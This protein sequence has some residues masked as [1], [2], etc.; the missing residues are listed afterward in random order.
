MTDLGDETP[1][2]NKNILINEND[3]NNILK[4]FGIELDCIN[5]NLYV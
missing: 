4:R 5:I 2:N 1:Y 3:V